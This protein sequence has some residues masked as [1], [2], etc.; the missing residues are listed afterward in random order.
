MESTYRR[1]RELSAALSPSHDLSALGLSD[2]TFKFARTVHEG[3][4]DITYI[5]QH[6]PTSAEQ[7]PRSLAFP[8]DPVQI[9]STVEPVSDA[10]HDIPQDGVSDLACQ[11]HRTVGKHPPALV[12]AST[13]ICGDKLY[14]FGG[15]RLSRRRSQLTAHLYELDLITRRWERLE[16]RGD[17]PAPRYFHSVCALGDTKLVCY[18]GMAPMQSRDELSPSSTLR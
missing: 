3:R 17:A 16:T 8:S 6:L 9:P 18:G 10:E 7:Q 13:T 15:R 1:P 14:V 11:I 4:A 12:G 2:H 5:T